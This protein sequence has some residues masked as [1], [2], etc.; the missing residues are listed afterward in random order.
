MAVTTFNLTGTGG[1][2]ASASVFFD[3]ELAASSTQGSR[4]AQ[5]LGGGRNAACTFVA[6]GTD[7]T[8]DV[9]AASGSTQPLEVGV[10]GGPF[11][12]V[13]DL[14]LVTWTAWTLFSGLSDTA[15]TVVIRDRGASVAN[16]GFLDRDKV[17]VVTGA[18]PALSA[19]AG[20][21]AGRQ[22][23]VGNA[24]VAL[25]VRV[26]GQPT[27]AAAS[28]GN[29][30][31]TLSSSNDIAYRFKA[32]I[33]TLSAWIYQSNRK[34]AL[35]IDGVRQAP[36]TIPAGSDWRR[37]TIAAGLDATAE[38]D[39]VLQFGFTGSQFALLHDLRTTGGSGVNTATLAVR[40]GAAFYGDSIT[41]GSSGVDGSSTAGYAFKTAMRLGC[42]CYNR[43]I[44]GTPVRNFGAGGAGCTTNAGESRTADVTGLTVAPAYVVILYGVNDSEVGS[45]N[46]GVA[47]SAAVFKTSYRAMT[48]AVLAGLPAAAVLC[49]PVLTTSG[50]ATA[51][52]TTIPSYR[53]QI[54]A[55][56]SETA[57]SRLRYVTGVPAVAALHPADADNTAVA[58]AI[59]AFAA[60]ARGRTGF[61]RGVTRGVVKGV[62]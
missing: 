7:C 21:E 23:R 33:S 13:P 10:D 50:N 47:V 57:N 56:V 12:A 38:H 27:A 4:S 16:Q 17:A 58:A 34:V 41:N 60:P 1:T 30:V 36:V 28:Q 43:G 44:G 20:Y 61:P 22:Y 35:W 59:A 5:R 53:T 40:P 9:Y 52:S 18:A 26:E 37:T 48:D 24:A 2:D 8:T 46:A 42:Q 6:T 25:Y 54:A 55:V 29:V 15:H 14:T 11:T 31:F 39:Y 19:P 45:C 3:G 62:A 51:D 32:T 49:V